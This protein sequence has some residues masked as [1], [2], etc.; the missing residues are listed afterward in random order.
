MVFEGGVLKL[1]VAN[2]GTVKAGRLQNNAN[3]S[4]FDLNTGAFR[5]SA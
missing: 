1:N 2:I 4:Y 3:T 5:I